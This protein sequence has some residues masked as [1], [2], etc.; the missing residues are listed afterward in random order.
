[1]VVSCTWSR[2]ECVRLA[3]SVFC[4]LV[5]AEQAESGVSAEGRRGDILCIGLDAADNLKKGAGK[6]G[7]RE[8][9][10]IEIEVIAQCTECWEDFEGSVGQNAIILAGT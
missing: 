2:Q 4:V 7:K 9:G 1:M 6:E 5:S 10:R 8:G 3:D